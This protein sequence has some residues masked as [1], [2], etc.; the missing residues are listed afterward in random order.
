M[1]GEILFFGGI[2]VAVEILHSLYPDTFE[3]NIYTLARFDDMQ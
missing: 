3:Y 1:L 2:Y